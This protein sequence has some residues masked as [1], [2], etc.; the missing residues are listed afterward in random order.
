ML[1]D[2]SLIAAPGAGPVWLPW[3]S[4]CLQL[5]ELDLQHVSTVTVMTKTPHLVAS[6]LEM[7]AGTKVYADAAGASTDVST[8][9]SNKLSA[10]DACLAMH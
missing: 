10:L 5:T 1:A 3:L 8:S 7:T 6:G 2:L 9:V 4:Q